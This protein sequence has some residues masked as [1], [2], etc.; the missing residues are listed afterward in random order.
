[1]I[2]LRHLHHGKWRDELFVLWDFV[3]LQANS[4]K[5]KLAEKRV[6]RSVAVSQIS[7]S[8][9]AKN[10]IHV[11]DPVD[12]EHVEVMGVQNIRFRPF[13]CCYGRSELVL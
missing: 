12:S 4:Q 7:I 6:E 10:L 3:L 2:H 5:L 9:Q 13:W 1:M 11:A 8:K